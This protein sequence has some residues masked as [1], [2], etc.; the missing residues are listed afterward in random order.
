M[1]A[2]ATVLLIS[3]ALLL[4]DG[5]GTDQN[6]AQ[7]E[8]SGVWQANL[9]GT[10]SGFGFITQ[11][12]INANGG[13]TIANFQF[14]NNESC[15]PYTNGSNGAASAGQLTDLTYNSGN[16]IVSGNFSFTIVESGNTLTLTST[17]V[18]GTLNGKS[19]SGGLIQG[20]WTLVAGSS[21]GCGNSSG[22]FTMTQSSSAT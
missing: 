15:F 14:L 7:Q 6:H 22:I 5:C 13:L 16:Q 9:T 10:S 11:F 19:L 1:K 4:A 3:L 12:T 20:T 2:V 21:T 8:A 17:S 18:N